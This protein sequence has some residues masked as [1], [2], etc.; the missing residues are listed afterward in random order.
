MLLN[1][2][3]MF[4]ILLLVYFEQ[5]KRTFPPKEKLYLSKTV[6]ISQLNLLVRPHFHFLNAI[7]FNSMRHIIFWSVSISS[8]GR[9]HTS[10]TIRKTKETLSIASRKN[11]LE[12]NTARTMVYVCVSWIECGKISHNIDR[13][14]I[15]WNCGKI[16]TF[17]RTL[18]PKLH[19]CRIYLNIKQLDALNFIMSLFNASTCFEHKCSWSGGQNCIIQ[20]LVSSN[21]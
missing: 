11:D 12:G 2:R 13:S 5:S 17:G 7:D 15:C 3:P 20:P 8:L 6:W 21:L 18:K 14:Q 4:R 10:H 9:K 16:Q 19:P 1:N